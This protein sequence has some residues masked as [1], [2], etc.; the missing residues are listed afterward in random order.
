M[1]SNLRIS[2]IM[3]TLNSEKTIRMSL[4]SIRKQ[5]FDQNL[6]EILIIDGGSTDK[7]REI[8][9]EYD[10][11]ILENPKIQPE[12]AKHLGILNAKS[13]Y[14]VFLDSDEVLLNR[15][16]FKEKFEYLEN[17]RTK[18]RNI[19][20]SGLKTPKGY[21]FVSDYINS[22]GDPF[23]LFVYGINGADYLWSLIKNK[24]LIVRN[25]N[26]VEI[27][28]DNKKII[29]I[30]DG[31]GH[32][33]DLQYLKNNFDINNLNISSQIFN[34]MVFKASHFSVLKNDFINHYGTSTLKVYFKKIN[35]RII[36]NI[37]YKNETAGFINRESR[38]P[39]YCKI[40]KII[41]IPF[42][43]TFIPAIIYSI[44]KGIKYKKSYL[45]ILNPF[46]MIYTSLRILCYYCLKILGIK[47][48][49]ESYG[50]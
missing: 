34:L 2:I 41:F 29:P 46:F 6:V 21:G 1:D 37:F 39:L 22:F 33:F 9:R 38:M 48:K 27:K 19:I 18:S 5:N 40:K 42:S 12:F 16:S 43:L 36:N 11:K 7:T 13:K 28:L 3:P 20:I 15:N 30:C 17:P 24:Y 10:C 32:F 26:F 50:K 8:A 45:F 31:G 4:E 49:L 47:P 44:E 14:A 35:F 25:E 23:S